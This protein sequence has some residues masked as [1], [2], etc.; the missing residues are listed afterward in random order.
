[1]EKKDNKITIQC[2][3]R[4]IKTEKNSFIAVTSQ[5]NGKYYKIK[6]KKECN[7]VPRKKGLFHLTL[8]VDEISVQYS[9]TYV[10]KDGKVREEN[11]TIWVDDI[12]EIKYFTAEE[13]KAINR[14]KVSSELKLD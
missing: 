4:E 14:D 8:D 7:N 5:I 1:M 6:F 9:K 11:P 3:A 13:L 12:I 2:Y 10:G